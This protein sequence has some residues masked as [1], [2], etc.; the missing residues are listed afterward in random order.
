M[1]QKSI[2]FETYPVSLKKYLLRNDKS[3]IIAEFKT[4]SPS[5]G[6]INPNANVE[7]VTVGYMQAGASALSVLTD[8]SFFGGSF[9]NLSIAR[10][11][12]YCPILQKD[13]I[14]DEYQVY[15]AKSNGADAILL[16]AAVL[17]KTNVEKLAKLANSFGMEVICEVHSKNEL[18]KLNRYIDIVGINN[19]NLSNFEVDIKQSM[20]LAPLIPSDL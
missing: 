10:K 7:K 1:L 19:R 11:Y 20:E 2:Y 13:F 3:G 15:E 14:L 6:D 4:K 16:I 12:N 9:R 8:T 18:N 17:S 5:K